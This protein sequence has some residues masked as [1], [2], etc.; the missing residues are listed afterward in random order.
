MA[1]W[2]KLDNW[3]KGYEATGHNPDG[4]VQKQWVHAGPF[5]FIQ[6]DLKGLLKENRMFEMYVGFKPTP[7]QSPQFD[8][9]YKNPWLVNAFIKLQN[10]KFKHNIGNLNCALRTPLYF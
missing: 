6:I 2:I 7:E 9:S 10:W 8:V 5:L 3:T 4:T 1:S